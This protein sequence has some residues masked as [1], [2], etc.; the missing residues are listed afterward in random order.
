MNTCTQI[1][2]TIVQLAQ[3]IRAQ[4]KYFDNCILQTT[5][6]KNSITG[7]YIYYLILYQ[8]YLYFF[9]FIC[10]FSQMENNTACEARTREKSSVL[11]HRNDFTNFATKTFQI[12]LF[13]LYYIVF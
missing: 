12:L 7:I 3:K 6:V 13:I 4:Q 1:I 10:I 2:S 11:L 8:N 5:Q 9:Q